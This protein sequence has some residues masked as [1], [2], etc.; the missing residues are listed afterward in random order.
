MAYPVEGPH[1]FDGIGTA[2]A[3]PPSHP[4]KIPQLMLE[5]NW[6]T[7][8]FNDPNEWPVDGSQ[9][10]VLSTGDETG[11]SQHADYVFGWKDDSLQYGMDAGCAGADCPGMA[12]QTLSVADQCEVPER[13]G[14]NYTG[15]ESYFPFLPMTR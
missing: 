7:T 6:D 11:Y 12:T 3:C 15:C 13:V 2:A 1:I 8:A 9:P 4:V 10:F 14:E 5:I